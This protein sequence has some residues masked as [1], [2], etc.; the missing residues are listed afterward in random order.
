MIT[1]IGGKLSGSAFLVAM[2]VYVIFPAILTIL[3]FFVFTRVP[4]S[5]ISR[6]ER[7]EKFFSLLLWTVIASYCGIF[8]TMS[9]LR[10]L[11]FNT[12][13]YDLGIYDHTMWKIADQG[14]WKYLA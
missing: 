12:A 10:Y 1:E 6:S 9:V 3:V 5:S 7:K 8:G 13:F 2:G 4:F 14:N 11:S